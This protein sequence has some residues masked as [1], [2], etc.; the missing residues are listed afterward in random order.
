[1]SLFHSLQ[2]ISYITANASNKQT[3]PRANHFHNYFSVY[4]RSSVLSMAQLSMLGSALKQSLLST[5]LW[6]LTIEMIL[7]IRVWS[8][9]ILAAYNLKEKVTN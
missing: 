3:K 9:K 2:A 5:P 1:M 8:P 4:L 7:Q 6:L